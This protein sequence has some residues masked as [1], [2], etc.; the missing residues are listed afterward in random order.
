MPRCL[1]TGLPEKSLRASYERIMAV[2][3]KNGPFEG[4]WFWCWSRA[5]TGAL[6]D[7][8]FLRELVKTNGV[9]KGGTRLYLVGAES[10]V[11]N[12]KGLLPDIR[13]GLMAMLLEPA[14]S[15]KLENGFTIAYV[16]G[17]SPG[18]A[19]ISLIKDKRVEFLFTFAWPEGIKE[20][21]QGS[22]A[23]AALYRSHGMQP[24]YHFATQEGIFYERSPFRSSDTT[25]TRFVG[26]GDA[27]KPG[28][29]WHY[30][31]N[32]NPGIIGPE[33]NADPSP[34]N[35]VEELPA[36]TNIFYQIDPSKLPSAKRTADHLEEMRQGAGPRRPPPG[37]SCNYCKGSQHFLRDCPYKRMNL[38]APERSSSTV[39]Q[40][41]ICHACQQPGHLIKDCPQRRPARESVTEGCWFCLA[42]PA[43]RKHLIVEVGEESYLARPREPLDE[44][45]CLIVPIEHATRP[46]QLNGAIMEDIHRLERRLAKVYLD[47]LTVVARLMRPL[48]HHWHEQVFSVGSGQEAFLAFA[49]DFLSKNQFVAVTAKP[50][51][52]EYF[53]LVIQGSSLFVALDPGAFFP[54][55]LPRQLIA[56]FLGKIDLDRKQLASRAGSS[57]ELERQEREGV[58]SLKA[59]L[60]Q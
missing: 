58:A 22:A 40:G 41:Y 45:H 19:D 28:E 25:T 27:S 9:I 50:E 36:P 49:S 29:R 4:G 52:S 26:L 14:G 60:S 46:E 31:L 32:I 35:T 10:D 53:E 23:L 7:V 17:A 1:I 51:N 12:L 13:A 59:R 30:A 2:V 33:H 24:R 8:D 47:K 44:D 54:A 57:E 37:Y 5:S 16:N 42:N 55:N 43:V 39:P 21:V 38:E 48:K 6:E 20:G 56:S 11:L 18:P 3:E 34:F 15:L